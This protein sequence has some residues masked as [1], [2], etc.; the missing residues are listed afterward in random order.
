MSKNKSTFFSNFSNIWNNL[1]AKFKASMIKKP[2]EELNEI[3]VVNNNENPHP[4][5]DKNAT[6]LSTKFSNSID[7]FNEILN[8]TIF[9]AFL[10]TFS[11]AI[12]TPTLPKAISNFV[13]TQS[14]NYAKIMNSIVSRMPIAAETQSAANILTKSSAPFI[15]L[16]AAFRIGIT[17]YNDIKAKN[18]VMTCAINAASKAVETVAESAIGAVAASV[19]GTSAIAL[20]AGANV[21]IASTFGGALVGGAVAYGAVKGGTYAANTAYDY[22]KPVIG[23]FTQSISDRTGLQNVAM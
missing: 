15:G 17:L 12:R 18:S 9:P 5:I 20:G 13:S 21:V 23:K 6:S 22:A 19:A 11:Q 10:T 3:I 4:Q 7:R 8:E 1:S 16:V 2:V 14:S